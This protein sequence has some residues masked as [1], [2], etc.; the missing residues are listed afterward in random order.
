MNLYPRL[1]ILTQGFEVLPN[2]SPIIQKIHN[3]YNLDFRDK[4]TGIPLQYDVYVKKIKVKTIKPK[5]LFLSTA[6]DD[7]AEYYYVIS[8]IAINTILGNDPSKTGVTFYFKVNGTIEIVYITY[9]I[10]DDILAVLGSYFSIFDLCARVL[11]LFYTDFFFQAELLN[12]VF[13]FSEHSSKSHQKLKSSKNIKNSENEDNHNGSQSKNF[14]NENDNSNYT[15]QNKIDNLPKIIPYSHY[16]PN[17]KKLSPESNLE[18][19]QVGLG[20]KA[21]E[22]IYNSINN[23]ESI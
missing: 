18:L 2:H 12:S 15:S 5:N 17:N 19:I 6:N 14:D 3:F 4:V 11:A 22:I 10:F 16:F 13:N 7:D 21:D 20:E 9:D 23:D 1:F 8:D